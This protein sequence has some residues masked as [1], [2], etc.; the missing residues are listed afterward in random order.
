MISIIVATADNGVIGQ[1][2]ELPWMLPAEMKYFK[3]LT[4]GHP[5]V[6]GRKTHESIT[7]ALP[8]RTNI[9]ISRDGQK[10]ENCLSA[11]SLEGALEL[12]ASSAGSEEIF[13]IGGETIYKLALLLADR[14]Y[15]TLVHAKINGNKFFKFNKTDWKQISIE[16]HKADDKNQYD[17]D[18]IV[19]DKKAS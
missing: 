11:T 16:H 17:F 14:L 13:V 5:I 7:R 4:T 12:A 19:L 8:G 9:V 10:F 1:D 3:N 6:M 18:F 2:N 15:L